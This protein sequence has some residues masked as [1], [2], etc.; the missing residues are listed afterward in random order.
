M[1]LG[2]APFLHCRY[3]IMLECW[4]EEPGKRPTFSKLRTSFDNMLM[5]EKKDPYID[6]QVD[7]SKPYYN[8][9]LAE[10]DPEQN[11]GLLHVG[12]TSKSS[13]KVSV[14]SPF[15]A[16]GV[17]PSH[18]D[19]SDTP[20]IFR[21]QRSPR[22]LSPVPAAEKLPRPTSLQLLTERKNTNHYVDDPSTRRSIHIS[23]PEWSLIGYQGGASDGSVPVQMSISG[24]GRSHRDEAER[25]GSAVPDIFISFS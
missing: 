8:P 6:L 16:K 4:Q 17:L 11:D 21:G 13:S 20:V 14:T 23:P 15:H 3:A 18:S 10:A 24:R 9:D 2:V 7:A 22:S 5:A 25:D 12:K 1:V 19:S